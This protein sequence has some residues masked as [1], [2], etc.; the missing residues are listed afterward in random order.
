[1]RAALRTGLPGELGS[2]VSKI[3]FVERMTIYLIKPFDDEYVGF[4]GVL[5]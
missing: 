2:K 5:E 1:V 3:I 4:V